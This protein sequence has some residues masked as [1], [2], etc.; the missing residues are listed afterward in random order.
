[1]L[2]E[3]SASIVEAGLDPLVS[4]SEPN[5]AFYLGL[6][7]YLAGIAIF[8]SALVTVSKTPAGRVF[9]QGMYR[10]S[11]HP[12]YLSFIV[13]LLGVSVATLSGLFL[14][15]ST[16]WLIFPLSHV[17]TEERS[18]LDMFGVAYQDYMNRTPKW[19]G[20]PGRIMKVT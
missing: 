1:M 17:N 14:L 15:L 5:D 7:L 9:T 12:L 6:A 3:I 20:I 13:I 8:M 16:G 11:R 18:C 2:P 19:I 4:E 10:F